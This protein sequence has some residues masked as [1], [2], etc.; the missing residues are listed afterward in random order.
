MTEEEFN[1]LNPG[2]KIFLQGSDIIATVMDEDEWYILAVIERA[3]CDGVVDKPKD[4]PE[5]VHIRLDKPQ[6]KMRCKT[7]TVDYIDAIQLVKKALTN[8]VTV[9]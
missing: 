2:D 4:Y 5:R 9:V 8:D 3:D 6:D 7:L 1:N